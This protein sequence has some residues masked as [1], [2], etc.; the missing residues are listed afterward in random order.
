[1]G[2]ILTFLVAPTPLGHGANDRLVAGLHRHVLGPHH[3]L[4][5]AAMAAQASVE[6]FPSEAR[7]PPCSRLSPRGDW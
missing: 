3:L 4:A 2:S 6:P 7:P 1:M 5:L